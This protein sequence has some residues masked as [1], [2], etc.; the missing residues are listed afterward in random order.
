MRQGFRRLSPATVVALLALVAA[1]GGSAY[2]A[3][4]IDGRSVKFKSLPGNRLKIGSVPANRL[5][6]GV[7]PP[8]GPGIVEPIT[9]SQ[10]DERSLGQ[11]PSAAYADVAGSA[12]SAVD[13]QT[14]V[15][16]INAVNSETVNGHSAGCGVGTI[17]FAGACWQTSASK[18]P[19]SAPVA[20]TSC[21]SQGASL[22]EA[23]QLAA[24]T[25]QA[26]IKL[27]SDE[28][29][30]DIANVSGVD[31]YSVITVTSTGAINYALSS[32][33]RNYRCVFPIVV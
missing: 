15:N 10:I 23:L 2:A 1:L 12:Q 17:P 14:A 21:A 20:A 29:S 8:P 9:G 25:Q 16:A 11:V 26:D 3:G 31:F 18:S 27:E 32:N 13:A 30:A 28:W 6:P 7:I 33:T 5:K 22:P 24:F 4:R 19:V